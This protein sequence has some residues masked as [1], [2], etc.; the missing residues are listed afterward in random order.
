MSKAITARVV[1]IGNSRGIRI[2][3]PLLKQL[4]SVVQTL[5]STIKVLERA[6]AT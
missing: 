5:A 6:S 3:K 1:R 4:G 2:P